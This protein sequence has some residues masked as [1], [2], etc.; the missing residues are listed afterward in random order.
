MF[1]SFLRIFFPESCPV[2]GK[3]SDEHKTAPICSLC[4]QTI[5]PYTGS[6]CRICGRPLASGVSTECGD[7]LKN[8][9]AFS[10]ARSFGLYEGTLKEAINYFKYYGI[11]RLSRPLSEMLL[12]MEIPSADAIIPVPLYKKRLRSRE[13]NQSA[14]LVRSLSK[15]TGIPALFNSLVKTRDTGPQVGL[16]ARD[17]KK[18]IR[19]A[20]GIVND[21]DIQGKDIV[22][23]DDVFTTGATVR[24]CSQLLK[25][26]G[27][28]N[29]YV[30]LL[31]HSRR[32]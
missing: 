24:E 21:K 3:D 4:W 9:P 6:V 7:C 27:A 16:Y 31:A 20:F 17:R 14:L 29:I 10:W 5:S 2:C 30:V 11:T 28:K 32:D 19:N 12:S 8:R 23:V 25:K 15:G 13:F 22:L 18:N 26:R 1:S